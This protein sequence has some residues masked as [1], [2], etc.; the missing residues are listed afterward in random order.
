M[1]IESVSCFELFSNPSILLSTSDTS[2]FMFCESPVTCPATTANPL[3]C[4]PALAASI[5]AFKASRFVLFATATI[6]AMAVFIS[7][8]R[9]LNSSYIA[10]IFLNSSSTSFVPLIRRFMSSRAS[11]DCLFML[12][13]LLLKSPDIF[14]IF[15]NSSP[16]SA[17]VSLNNLLSLSTAS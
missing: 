4:S 2:S 12:F 14:S 5:E 6:P 3:P 1:S 17:I 13:I 11:S 15:M 16:K 7:S 8:K 9:I 10:E